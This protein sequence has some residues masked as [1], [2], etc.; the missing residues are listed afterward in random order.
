MLSPAPSWDP[1][2]L[3]R[4]LR[5]LGPHLPSYLIPERETAQSLS[6]REKDPGTWNPVSLSPSPLKIYMPLDLGLGKVLL[7]EATLP[8]DSL[9]N[10]GQGLSLSG[11]QSPPSRARDQPP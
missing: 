8:L 2:L 3:L 10:L 4:L 5:V 1:L 6:Q 7:R 11:S 9:K